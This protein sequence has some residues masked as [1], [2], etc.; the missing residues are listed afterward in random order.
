MIQ[1]SIVLNYLNI[2]LGFG[3][4]Q[5]VDVNE[6]WQAVSGLWELEWPDQVDLVTREL[7][8]VYDTIKEVVPNLW[9][10]LNPDVSQLLSH[11]IFLNSFKDF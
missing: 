8:V 7:P 2:S 9:S 5:N 3:P 6:S 1:A 4:F 11:I 10:E